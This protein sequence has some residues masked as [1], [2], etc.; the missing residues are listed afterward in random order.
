MK[1]HSYYLKK[2]NIFVFFIILLINLPTSPIFAK[3][4]ADI[5]VQNEIMQDDTIPEEALPWH[6]RIKKF[7]QK[8]PY[9]VVGVAAI[10]SALVC[11]LATGLIISFLK[12]NRTPSSHRDDIVLQSIGAGK[13]FSFDGG[14]WNNITYGI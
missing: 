6:K 8:R 13:D 9:E 7:I 5:E 11:S 1:L 2:K 10:S 14:S 4:I 3:E 12:N